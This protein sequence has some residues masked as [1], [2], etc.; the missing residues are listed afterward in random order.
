MLLPS[1]PN[2]PAPFGGSSAHSQRQM[3]VS[4]LLQPASAQ[5]DFGECCLADQQRFP[6]PFPG[7][8]FFPSFPEHQPNPG[9]FAARTHVDGGTPAFC[10][11]DRRPHQD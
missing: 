1:V 2:C 4:V 5:A 6:A 3:H 8:S 9:S 11:P 7:F 10:R